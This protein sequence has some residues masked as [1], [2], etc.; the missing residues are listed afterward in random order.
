MNARV[1]NPMKRVRFSQGALFSADPFARRKGVI[2]L[3]TKVKA[4]AIGKAMAIQ[5]LKAMVFDFSQHVRGVAVETLA[6]IIGWKKTVEFIENRSSKN[7]GGVPANFFY[8]DVR[9]RRGVSWGDEDWNAIK[10]Q[11]TLKRRLE[12][13]KGRNGKPFSVNGIPVFLWDL[14]IQGNNLG[15]L[16]LISRDPKILAPKYREIVALHEFGEMFNS[17]RLGDALMYNYAKRNGLLDEFL[18]RY[19]QYKRRFS[20][21]ERN[22]IK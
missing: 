8:R 1:S 20:G 14:T 15:G 5:K 22:W 7:F 6:R 10:N 16:I 9:D 21:I 13:M 4:G 17:H 11:V 18:Q 19:K 3:G 12:R 2:K